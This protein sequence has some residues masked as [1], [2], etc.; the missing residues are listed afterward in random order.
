MVSTKIFSF[1]SFST[2]SA[3][4]PM[5]PPYTNLSYFR[6]QHATCNTDPDQYAPVGLRN[7]DLQQVSAYDQQIVDFLSSLERVITHHSP[8][9]ALNLNS[10]P[11]QSTDL[12][13]L[14][15]LYLV[16]YLSRSSY[17]IPFNS[18]A[19]LFPISF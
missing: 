17:T 1:H 8:L 14:V 4:L 15:G 19:T 7:F 11:S 5:R 6:S 18:R 9:T 2:S 10:I 16:A 12:C 13:G 3:F